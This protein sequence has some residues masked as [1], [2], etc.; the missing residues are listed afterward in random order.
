MLYGS[1]SS[2][3]FGKYHRRLLLDHLGSLTC[4]GDDGNYIE[5]EPGPASTVPK[6]AT[7]FAVASLVRARSFII[8]FLPR[9]FARLS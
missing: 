3:D 4:V 2:R 5:P 1:A 8:L 6:P 9:C 7:G